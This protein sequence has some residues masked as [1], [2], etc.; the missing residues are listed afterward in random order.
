MTSKS[1][2][3]RDADLIER[4]LSALSCACG[5]DIS[6]LMD[7]IYH[8]LFIFEEREFG[9]YDA[10]DD[11]FVAG[12][13]GEGFEGAGAGGVVFEVVGIYVEVLFSSVFSGEKWEVKWMWFWGSDLLGRAFRRLC[14]RRRRRSDGCRCSFR[15]RDGCPGAYPLDA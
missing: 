15:G 7:A 3:R 13:V 11:V 8:F 1:A 5:Y 12:K 4:L 6:G 9:C 10:E 14:R 2:L